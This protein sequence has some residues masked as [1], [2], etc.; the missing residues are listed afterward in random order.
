LRQAAVSFKQ[1][2]EDAIAYMERAYRR[3][4]DDVARLRLA[5]EWFGSREA[6]SLKASEI[7]AKLSD[8]A[9]K[10]G[11]S[12]S[13]YNKHR[14]VVSLAFSRARRDEKVE[15]N[16]VR[17]VAHREE[18]P[19]QRLRALTADEE[20]KLRKVIREHYP[21]HEDEFDFAL[22][23]GL[24]QGSQYGLTWDMVRFKDRVLE[25]PRTKNGQRLVLPLNDEALAV[26]R[27]LRSRSNGNG[28]VFVSEETGRPFKH[29]PKHWFTDAVRK[30][31]VRDF[32]WHDLRHCFATRLRAQG[33]PLEDIADL[34]GHKHLIMTRRYA[35][36]DMR[37]LH[38]AVGRLAAKRTDTPTDTERSGGQ[39]A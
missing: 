20:Q 19:S 39:M 25:I 10:R 3:P 32:H 7:E 1:I 30:A 9:A 31:G 37:R 27:R 24:R 11:W 38:E 12:A 15:A 8:E 23:T 14:S 18:E 5:I 22:H 4:A 26:L 16:P 13:T 2:A 6:A 35:H 34:L 29:G 28:H 21:T 36:K 33:T 17:D